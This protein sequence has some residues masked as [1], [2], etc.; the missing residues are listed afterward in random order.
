VGL[1]WFAFG[2]K[3]WH[4]AFMHAFRAIGGTSGKRASILQ[5]MQELT[6]R[7]EEDPFRVERI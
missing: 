2:Q 5:V 7:I 1:L 6:I 3:I 4:A